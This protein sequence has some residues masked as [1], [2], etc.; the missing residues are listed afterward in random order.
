METSVI[1]GKY[2]NILHKVPSTF[3]SCFASI[4]IFISA[5]FFDS[6]GKL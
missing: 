1:K 4:G 3:A 5:E 6:K 2:F